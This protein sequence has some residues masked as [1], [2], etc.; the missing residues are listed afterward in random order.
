MVG[1]KTNITI[2]KENVMTAPK[3]KV[4]AK[5]AVA[6]KKPAKKL[7]KNEAAIRANSNFANHSLRRIKKERE[8]EALYEKLLGRYAEEGWSKGGMVGSVD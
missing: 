7:E 2:G 3:K 8:K 5:K 6:K 4:V 1:D